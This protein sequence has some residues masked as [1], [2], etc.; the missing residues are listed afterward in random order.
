MTVIDIGK[1]LKLEEKFECYKERLDYIAAL[2]GIHRSGSDSF[3]FIRDDRDIAEDQLEFVSY[4]FFNF[5]QDLDKLKESVKPDAIMQVFER[6][7]LFISELDEFIQSY[8]DASKHDKITTV[9]KLLKEQQEE[10]ND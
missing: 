2:E 9:A 7:S 3:Y 10:N 5:E 4:D 8:E 1:Y 6:L